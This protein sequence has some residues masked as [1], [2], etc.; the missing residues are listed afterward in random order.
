MRT[1]KISGSGEM[2][3]TLAVEIRAIHRMLKS[4]VREHGGSKDLTPSQISVLVR[5]EKDGAATMSSLAR[6]EGMR[7]QSMTE[8][9]APLLESGLLSRSP[10]GSGSV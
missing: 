2:A 7:P 10:D 3:G 5:L 1:R 8:V 9:T 6:A 4:R